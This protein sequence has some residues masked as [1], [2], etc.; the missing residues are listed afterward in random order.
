MHL[1][2]QLA[3]LPFELRQYIREL[4]TRA[5]SLQQQVDF[6]QE[7]FRLAQLKRF[8]PSSEKQGGQGSLFNEAEQDAA[9]PAPEEEQDPLSAVS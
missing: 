8:A 5:A 7:Q 2:D 6:L 3:A 9:T 1:P 4:E